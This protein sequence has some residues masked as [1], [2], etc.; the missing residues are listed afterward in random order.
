MC[1][2]IRFEP[3]MGESYFLLIV[4]GFI[5]IRENVLTCKAFRIFKQYIL[6]DLVVWILVHQVELICQSVD[7][8]LQHPEFLSLSEYLQLVNEH[9]DHPDILRR[10]RNVK[11][12]F[13]SIAVA[14]LCPV[15]F[16]GSAPFIFQEAEILFDSG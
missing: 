15:V 8:F 13:L 1:G 16:D 14:P 7:G 5:D 11:L 12:P 6:I 3:A 10:Q 2:L 4:N 9:P